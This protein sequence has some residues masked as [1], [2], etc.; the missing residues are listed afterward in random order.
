MVSILWN[1]QGLNPDDMSNRIV[2]QTERALTTT[3]GRHRAH[4]VAIAEWHRGGEGIFPAACGYYQG[5]R[6][7]NGDLADPT[8]AIATGNDAAA[9]NHLQRVQR[10]DY[11]AGALGTRVF[12]NSNCLIMA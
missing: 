4:R 6:A 8:Q 9:C 7:G 2:F 3:G 12:L 5:N 11:P 1:Y 10:A